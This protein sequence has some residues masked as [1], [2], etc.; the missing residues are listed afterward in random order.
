MIV[1]NSVIGFLT[2]AGLFL[3]G[4][5]RGFIPKLIGCIF[6]LLVFTVMVGMIFAESDRNGQVKATALCMLLLFVPLGLIFAMFK[7]TRYKKERV[8]LKHVRIEPPIKSA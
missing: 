5:F 2:I 4:G 1:E 3:F 7:S 6:I 8:T